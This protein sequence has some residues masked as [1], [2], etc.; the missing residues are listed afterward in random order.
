MVPLVQEQLFRQIDISLSS[1]LEEW[2]N[3]YTEPFRQ[4]QTQ[5]LERIIAQLH[6]RGMMT[7][8]L[9]KDHLLLYAQLRRDA[10]ST[11][12]FYHHYDI[13]ASDKQQWTSLIATLA[14]L[15]AYQ[16][17]IGPLPINIK[18]LLDTGN[19]ID[20]SSMSCIIAEYHELL[21]ADGCIWYTISQP[22]DIAGSLSLGT[23]GLLCVE[24]NVQTASTNLHSMHGAIVPNAAWRLLWALNGLKSPYEEIL[25]EGFY[26]GLI[27]AQDDAIEQL[28]TTQTI[29]PSL[30]QQLGREQFLLGL[31][32][33]Q[34]RY[35]HL[36]TPTC[37]INGIISGNTMTSHSEATPLPIIP[38]RARAQLDFH[39]V[40]DQDPQDIFAKLQHHLQSQGFHDIQSRM[41]YACQPAY[42]PFN[43]PFVQTVSHAT[44]AAY[45][46]V[47]DILPMTV[48]NYPIAPFRQILNIP[49]VLA[50][51]GYTTPSA[52]NI[53]DQ[54]LTAKIKQ[55]AMIVEEMAHANHTTQ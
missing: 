3:F 11:L 14:A 54:D 32:G 2:K 8:F 42:T 46:R 36:L 1:Y 25:I 40:P 44:T 7:Q 17:V 27:S 23:K 26:D 52:Q 43:H 29:T 55:V 34:M 12:L 45:A 15:D 37:T 9:G 20:N 31:Q 16:T 35:A 5:T 21:R 48:G 18:W 13:H 10:P 33:F 30:A 50:L 19:E 22:G 4:N 53:Q 38:A 51:M 28:H 39:L 41:L 6:C 49:I 24:L 47:P